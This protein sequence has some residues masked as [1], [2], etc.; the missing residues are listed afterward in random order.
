MRY[1]TLLAGSAVA[2]A[3]M[4]SAQA[5]TPHDIVVLQY[6]LTLEHLEAA[7]YKE[8]LARY[9]PYDF[10]DA[11]YPAA[12]P[13]RLAQIGAQEATHV[14][15]LEGILRSVGVEPTKPCVGCC[16]VV[17]ASCPETDPLPEN[18]RPTT[19]ATT[20]SRPSSLPR[21]FSRASEYRELET[22]TD[23][24]FYLANILSCLLS[25]YLGKAPLI[26]SKAYLTAAGEPR[27]SSFCQRGI[28]LIAF[29]PCRC[30]PHGRGSPPG[31]HLLLP[32]PGRHPV[33][34]YVSNLP[35][36]P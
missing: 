35:S 20:A 34:L 21:A 22:A 32:G 10:K 28:Q 5:A 27:L 11:D 23:P 31:S 4:V 26:D 19:S 30:H 8:G 14:T 33:A 18:R 12:V 1:S 6:A 7:F 2:A 36:L 24:I 9:S 29:G 17:R 25:A 16:I 15:A 3:S 13:Q